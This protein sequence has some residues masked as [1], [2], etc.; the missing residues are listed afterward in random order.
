MPATSGISAKGHTGIGSYSSCTTVLVCTA[1][2]GCASKVP[3]KHLYSTALLAGESQAGDDGLL[4]RYHLGEN[5]SNFT[6]HLNETID[7]FRHTETYKTTY[8]ITNALC[9][10]IYFIT[11]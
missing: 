2:R 7:V 4:K 9:G 5:S 10:I 1:C 8:C 3:A 11:D 6:G